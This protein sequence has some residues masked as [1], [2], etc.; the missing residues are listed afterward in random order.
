M[1]SLRK[2]R[3]PTRTVSVPGTDDSFVVRGISLADV[4]VLMERHGQVL[5]TIYVENI[6]G[7]DGRPSAVDIAQTLIKT[8]PQAAAC[9]IAIA[10]GDVNDEDTAATLPFPIQVDALVQIAELTFHSEDALGNL[11]ATVINAATS[12]TKAVNRLN[13]LPTSTDGGGGS[14]ESLPT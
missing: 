7:A 4:A 5:N 6:G 8:A 2:L 13:G 12:T 1:G 3:L 14:A 10:S 9:I 11:I